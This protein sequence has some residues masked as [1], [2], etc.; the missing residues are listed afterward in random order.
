MW[1]A[2][3]RSGS[4]LVVLLPDLDGAGAAGARGRAGGGRARVLEG[5]AAE[6]RADAAQ[7]LRGMGEALPADVRRDT[8]HWLRLCVLLF[9]PAPEGVTKTEFASN[10]RL[11]RV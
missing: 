5:A 8:L 11:V 3:R 10:S 7:S 6:A 4:G 1:S 9:V 2:L